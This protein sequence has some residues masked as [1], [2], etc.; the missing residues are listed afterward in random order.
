M[1]DS[2]V[3]SQPVTLLHDGTFEGFLG[4]VFEAMRSGTSVPRIESSSSHQGEFFETTRTLE[5]RSDHALRVWNGIEK[6][7]GKDISAMVHAAFLAELPGLET[8]LWMYLKAMFAHP[9]SARNVLDEHTHAVYQAAQK[10]RHEAHLFQGF[11]R[12]SQAPDGSMFSVIAPTHNVLTL[13]GSHFQHRFPGMVW[14]IADSRRGLCLH[15]N[16]KDVELAHCDPTSLPKDARDV[17]H[18]A[19]PEDARFQALWRCFYDAVNIK[20]RHNTRQMTR[21]LPRKYWQYLPERN[22]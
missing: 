16:G 19:D 14:L 8:T 6:H 1:L 4:C 15:S 18:L 12:F 22:R 2:I 21:L 11:V 3:S 17:S 10:V 20:E 9:D 13:L 7:A 5:T